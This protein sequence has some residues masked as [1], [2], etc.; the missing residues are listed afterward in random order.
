VPAR[1][2]RGGGASCGTPATRGGEE[3]A[4]RDPGA[5]GGLALLRESTSSTNRGRGHWRWRAARR[6]CK[7]GAARARLRPR[8]GRGL[9]RTGHLL[10]C[11]P[12]LG[13]RVQGRDGGGVVESGLGTP[14][15]GDDSVGPA[16]SDRERRGRSGCIG[17]QANL[18]YGL[19]RWVAKEIR[20]HGRTSAVG[21]GP[22]R[23]KG[24]FI[25]R[26]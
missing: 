10:A 5:P 19:L 15:V 8:G 24:L 23:K 4:A 16:V 12:R 14:E 13:R 25:F 20:G 17:P 11:G 3:G 26:I 9:N 22:N 7:G 2:A 21:L 6:R 18:G 1:S